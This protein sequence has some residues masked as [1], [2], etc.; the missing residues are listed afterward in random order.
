[1]TQ[2]SELD[3]AFLY[4]E[5]ERTPL[6][7]G[8]AFVFKKSTIHSSFSFKRLRELIE[9]KLDNE[10]FFRKR[11]VESSLSLD[12]PIWEDDSRFDID[13]HMSHVRLA[14]SPSPCSLNELC[15]TIFS[16]GLDRRRPLWHITYVD[17]LGAGAEEQYDEQHFALIIRIHIAALDGN[18]GEDILS[19]LLHVSPE[20]EQLGELPS[21]EPKIAPNTSTWLDEAYNTASKLPKHLA[22][23][24]KETAAAAFYGTL[25]DKLAQL[26]LPLALTNTTRTPVNQNVSS[27]RVIDN[28]V[29]SSTDIRNIRQKL[30]EVTTNDIIMGI[31]AE[32]LHNYLKDNASN[33]HSELIALSPISVR[34]TSLEVKA[35]NQLAASLFS[36]SNKE[37]DPILRIKRIN[38][39]ARSS[40]H[41]DAAISA[42][43]LTELVPSCM[44]GLSARV[45]SE[46]LL[47]QKHQPVFNLPI[48]N[49]PGPQFPMF[50]EDNELVTHICAGPLFDGI[51]LGINVVS[52]N[53]HFSV[54]ATYCPELVGVDKHFSSYLQQALNTILTAIEEEQGE[55]VLSEPQ[56]ASEPEASSG[57]IEDAVG[58]VS[59][60]FSFNDKRSSR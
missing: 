22:W 24:A 58:L 15:A 1:M 30:H 20:L 44:V 52:Y 17:E 2:L 23:L 43:R 49:V 6:H 48:T 11:V 5:N 36:L 41:Y 26:K 10:H 40:K 50:L 8:G 19:Q 54:T 39:T 31:C 35:G 18:T 27:K 46:F 47:A 56:E 45:Y 59:S 51:G 25:S 53:G 55:Q 14:G 32:A 60:L 21:W 7:V 42:S 34:S 4:L 28:L 57:F 12:L 37:N 9:H 33:R 16:Q 3:A 38:Q 29:I 13:N